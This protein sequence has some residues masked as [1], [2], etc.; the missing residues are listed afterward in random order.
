MSDIGSGAIDGPASDIFRVTPMD[1]D[2]GRGA[3]QGFA[4]FQEEEELEDGHEEHDKPSSPAAPT[5]DVLDDV[6]LSDV[7]KRAIEDGQTSEGQQQPQ[8]LPPDY[9]HPGAI[10]Y[11]Q[12]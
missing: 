6:L 3:G 8:E 7:A 5:T 2:S 10:V 4:Q 12:A 9:E 1:R 11:L